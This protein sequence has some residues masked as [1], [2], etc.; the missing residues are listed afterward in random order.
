M[1]VVVERVD[2]LT[3]GV[4]LID[5]VG[6]TAEF[7]GTFG[8]R[9]N[10][11]AAKTSDAAQPT[12]GHHVR[13]RM[14]AGLMMAHLCNEAVTT[15][16]GRSRRCDYRDFGTNIRNGRRVSRAKQTREALQMQC[17]SCAPQRGLVGVI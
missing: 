4:D 14:M 16:A 13:R 15:T 10:S 6:N 5:P 2:R 9:T 12:S 7:F 17:R 1:S 3:G 8:A 11:A